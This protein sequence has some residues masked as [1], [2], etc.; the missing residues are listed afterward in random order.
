MRVREAN[1]GRLP[2]LSLILHGPVSP[3]LPVRV[4]GVPD[5]EV[6]PPPRLDVVGAVPPVAEV[7]HRPPDLVA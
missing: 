2:H 4:V 1:P 3:E 5:D 7:Q 6:R